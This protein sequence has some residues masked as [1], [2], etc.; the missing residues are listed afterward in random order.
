[1][2][3]INKFRAEICYRMKVEH[4]V[5][6]SK[7][8]NCEKFMVK[9]CVPGKDRSMD[10]DHHEVTTGEGY[11]KEFF[12]EAEKKA[13][14]Q[15]EKEDREAEKAKEQIEKEDRET[16]EAAPAPATPMGIIAPAPAVATPAAIAEPKISPA[17]APQALPAAS[18]GISKGEPNGKLGDDE[19]YYY[20]KG[21]K[22]PVRLHMDE[23]L[24]LPTQGYWGKLVSHDDME[25]ATEDWGVEFGSHSGQGT[26]ESHCRKHCDSEWCIKWGYC[27]NTN[28]KSGVE[29]SAKLFVSIFVVLISTL[30][31][32]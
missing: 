18:A 16:E 2:D 7:F 11:C 31:C 25:T 17:P 9:A 12:P 4:G 8:E 5:E 27:D 32:L 3:A 10:G 28:H 6:F 15:I 20:K 30:M 26:Y 19:A 14:E 24:K 22:D 23:N 21:G 29:A 13:K 1:M